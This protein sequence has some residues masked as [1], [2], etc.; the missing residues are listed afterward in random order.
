M[1]RLLLH[2]QR[3]HQVNVVS[4]HEFVTLINLFLNKGG[5]HRDL[6]VKIMSNYGFSLPK[7]MSMHKPLLTKGARKQ[8]PTASTSKSGENDDNTIVGTVSMEL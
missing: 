2:I 3:P 5:R 6:S 8:F 4:I 1:G 7:K